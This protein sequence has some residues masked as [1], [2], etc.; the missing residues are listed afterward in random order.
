DPGVRAPLG[1]LSFRGI[2]DMGAYT[3]F[4]DAAYL[5][6][7]GARALSLAM[8]GPL[9]DPRS[10]ATWAAGLQTTHGP[11]DRLLRMY[12]YDG[13]FD[14]T[15]RE[16]GSQ[17]QYFDAIEDVPGLVLRL[18]YVVERVPSWQTPVRRALR[19]CGVA[20]SDFEK[21]FTFRRERV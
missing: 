6:R 12:W 10:V 9:L 18:G 20:S 2:A 16:Y 1:A 14:P 19:S 7:S 11:G 17:R 21:H 4:V 3:V 5:E 13:A 8:P 15:H